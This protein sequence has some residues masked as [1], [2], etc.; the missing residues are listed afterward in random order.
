MDVYDRGLWKD[1]PDAQEKREREGLFG[2]VKRDLY[3]EDETVIVG[4]ADGAYI[5]LRSPSYNWEGRSDAKY[6]YLVTIHLRTY[7]FKFVASDFVSV[8][9]FCREHAQLILSRNQDDLSQSEQ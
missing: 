8:L 6:P 1:D 5:S 3:D 2:I 7:W 9:M 4:R